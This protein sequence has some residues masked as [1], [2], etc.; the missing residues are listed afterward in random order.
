MIVCDNCNVC[1]TKITFCSTNCRVQYHRR[2]DSVTK[3]KSQEISNASVTE[4]VSNPVIPRA[5][6]VN[7][8]KVSIKKKVDKNG[9]CPHLI[10]AEGY[11]MECKE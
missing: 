6:I 7:T 2:Y 11:C 3:V 9:Y 5:M 1:V 10:K 8:P 4:V